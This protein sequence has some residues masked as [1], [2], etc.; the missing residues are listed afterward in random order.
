MSWMIEL[1]PEGHLFRKVL[2]VSWKTI[3]ELSE[4]SGGTS[5][6]LV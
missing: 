4:E 1:L 6:I 2:K 5:F 3:K